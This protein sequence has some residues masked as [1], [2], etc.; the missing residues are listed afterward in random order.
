MIVTGDWQA[1][2]ELLLVNNEDVF[3]VVILLLFNISFF[4]SALEQQSCP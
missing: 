4:C 1:T 3:G 2:K